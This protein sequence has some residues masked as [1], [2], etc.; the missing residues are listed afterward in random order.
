[1]NQRALQVAEIACTKAK[2]R[3]ERLSVWLS[4]EKREK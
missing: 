2:G 1:M 3:T 4:I